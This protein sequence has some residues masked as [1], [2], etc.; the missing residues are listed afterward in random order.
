[1]PMSIGGSQAKYSKNQVAFSS[2]LKIILKIKIK[3]LE[4]HIS[5]HN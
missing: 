3:E 1:M 4:Q 2:F 5:T